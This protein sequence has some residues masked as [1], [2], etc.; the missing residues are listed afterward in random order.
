VNV[1]VA[2]GVVEGKVV[3]RWHQAISQIEF[4]PD[5]AYQI[6]TALRNAACDATGV[7]PEMMGSGKMEITNE[8]RARI[9]IICG[10][11]VRSL[12]EQGKTPEQITVHVVDYVLGETTV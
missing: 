12:M 7:T 3:A 4:N 10:K 2:I 1:E 5:N 6:G 11:I 8:G 9:L